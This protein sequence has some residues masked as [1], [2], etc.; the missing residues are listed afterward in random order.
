MKRYST[1]DLNDGRN[2][3]GIYE[4]FSFVREVASKYDI[5]TLEVRTRYQYYGIRFSW[6]VSPPMTMRY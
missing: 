4:T 2:S 6:N 5:E 3:P 1:T